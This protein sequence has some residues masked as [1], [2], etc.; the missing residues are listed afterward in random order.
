MKK[1]AKSK[2]VVALMLSEAGEIFGREEAT[3]KLIKV[4]AEMERLGN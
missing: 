4:F 2:K 1:T 3:N